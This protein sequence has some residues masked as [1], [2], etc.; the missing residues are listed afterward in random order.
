MRNGIDLVCL[1]RF[2]G[3]ALKTAFLKRVFTDAEI[4]GSLNARTPFVRLAG[5]FAAKEACLKALGTGFGKEAG[6][7]DIEVEY[8]E[9]GPTLKLHRGAQRLLG[10]RSVFLSLAYSRELAVAAV[11]IE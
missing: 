8:G 11:L 7:K 1:S 2:K 3:A 10:G 6:L 4:S 9:A 5:A